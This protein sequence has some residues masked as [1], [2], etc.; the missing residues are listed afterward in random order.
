MTVFDVDA[1]Q[2]ACRLDILAGPVTLAEVFQS[3]V[4]MCEIEREDISRS[5]YEPVSLE[6]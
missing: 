2:F 6:S 4:E 3:S 1:T 5:A